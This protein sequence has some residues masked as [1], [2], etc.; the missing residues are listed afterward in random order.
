[1][2]YLGIDFGKKRIGLALGQLI[3]KGAGVID[4]T[5][6]LKEVI[7]AI[8]QICLENEVSGVVIG[9]P[10][11]PSGSPGELAEDIKIFAGKLKEATGLP[12]HFEEEGF[13]SVEAE[14]ILKESGK[15][16]SRKSGKTDEM[17]AILILEQY[18]N[19]L[20]DSNKEK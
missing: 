15:N 8:K 20:N 14:E 1:M 6:S 13:T 16:Y 19:H 18:I 7:E 11:K 3:P 5:K 9:L 4:G 2:M 10:K 12:I 17:A